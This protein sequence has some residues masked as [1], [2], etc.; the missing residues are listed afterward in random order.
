MDL[1]LTLQARSLAALIDPEFDLGA[2]PQAVPTSV[3]N[4]IATSMLESMGQL[5]RRS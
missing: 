5:R 3:N 1:G 4:R 2:G